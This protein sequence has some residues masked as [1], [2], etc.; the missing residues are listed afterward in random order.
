MKSA[1]DLS[2][3]EMVRISTEREDGVR[4]NEGKKH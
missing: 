3:L 2:K 1:V 4:K